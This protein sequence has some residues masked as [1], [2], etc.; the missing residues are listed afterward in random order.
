M[1]SVELCLV[2]DTLLML[3]NVFRCENERRTFDVGDVMIVYDAKMMFM[4]QK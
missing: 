4:T 1:F 2:G 3:K